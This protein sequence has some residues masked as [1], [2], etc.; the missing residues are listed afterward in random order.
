MIALLFLA[1]GAVFGWVR[2][3]RRGGTTADK[4][5]YAAAHGFAFLLLAIAGGI[6]IDL[7]G[8]FSGP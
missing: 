2:A 8:L 1:L 5:Q 6:F 7:T 4:L 3:S